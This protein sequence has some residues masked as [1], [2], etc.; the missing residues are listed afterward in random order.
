MRT[1][2]IFDETGLF[3]KSFK[4]S[5]NSGDS[6]YRLDARKVQIEMIRKVLRAWSLFAAFLR[7]H[8]ISKCRKLS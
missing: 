3:G 5:E 2:K 6:L 7:K 1:Q 8:I 4:S